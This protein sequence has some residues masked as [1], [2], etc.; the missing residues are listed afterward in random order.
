MF[1]PRQPHPGE[2]ISHAIRPELPLHA[3]VDVVRAEQMSATELSRLPEGELERLF[4]SQ[5]HP[6]HRRS[7]R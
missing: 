3:T 7:T 2:T 4:A 1:A 6:K 5:Y